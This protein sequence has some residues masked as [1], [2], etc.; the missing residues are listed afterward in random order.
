MEDES[1]F[2]LDVLAFIHPDITFQVF[3]A[4]VTLPDNNFSYG[5]SQFDDCLAAM[6]DVAYLPSERMESAMSKARLLLGPGHEG[7]W[8]WPDLH[9]DLFQSHCTAWTIGG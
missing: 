3:G 1:T 4:D 2:D 9:P 6:A 5:G 8:F 7:C